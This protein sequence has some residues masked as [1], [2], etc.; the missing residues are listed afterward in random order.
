MSEMHLENKMGKIGDCK[1]KI[2]SLQVPTVHFRAV[3]NSVLKA[4]KTLYC[5]N[6]G[7]EGFPSAFHTLTYFS[8]LQ[9]LI[10]VK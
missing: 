2:R 8:Y 7:R 6:W 10:S 1:R 3:S 5:L 4:D 9:I